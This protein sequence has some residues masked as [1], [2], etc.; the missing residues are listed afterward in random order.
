VSVS[1]F[2]VD[3]SVSLCVSVCEDVLFVIVYVD[4]CL[5]CWVL[6]FLTVHRLSSIPKQMQVSSRINS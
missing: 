4:V 2:F 5:I 3:V 6:W 1:A